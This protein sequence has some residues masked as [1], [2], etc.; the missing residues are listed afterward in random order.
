V[1]D[2]KDMRELVITSLQ[3][4]FPNA[5]FVE[6]ESGREAAQK[7][8]SLGDRLCFITSD[9]HMENGNGD[10]VFHKWKETCFHIP[11]ILLTSEVAQARKA[12]LKDHPNLWERLAFLDKSGDFEELQNAFQR[13]LKKGF[14][15]FDSKFVEEE[16]NLNVPLFLSVG[17]N[18]IIRYCHQGES[19]SRGRISKLNEKGVDSFLIPT[20]DALEN[21][22]SWPLKPLHERSKDNQLSFKDSF[23]QFK[24]IHVDILTKDYVDPLCLKKALHNVESDLQKYE[25]T[26]LFEWFLD[27][28]LIRKNYV[29]NHSLLLST[30][31]IMA[32]QEMKLNTPHNRKILIEACLFHDLFKT[33]SEAM[34]FDLYGEENEANSKK[35]QKYLLQLLDLAKEMNL[36]QDSDKVL[37]AICLGINGH[38]NSSVNHKLAAIAL[39]MHKVTNELY[40]Q[41]FTKKISSEFL[42]KSGE[43]DTQIQKAMRTIFI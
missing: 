28:G 21:G 29:L 15:R 20:Q 31:C 12:L 3:E 43:G 22:F 13:L 19:L 39:S 25:Q 4:I 32:L 11:F 33:D 2:I 6:A 5:V 10:M 40:S 36:P 38:Q 27:K 26:K 41:K 34:R 16:S 35:H 1:D 9:F 7:I 18:K 24:V 14:I 42:Q 30:L 37:K 23:E 8:E 17:N